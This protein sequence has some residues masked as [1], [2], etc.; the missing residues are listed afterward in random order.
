MNWPPDATCKRICAL[1]ALAYGS[2]NVGESTNALA[3]LKRL[4]AELG[5]SDVELA[6]IAEYTEKE[7]GARVD[8]GET[9][10]RPLNLLE[11]L[12][13]LLEASRIILPLAQAIT[14][15]L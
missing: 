10:E 14:A 13:L 12:L 8:L 5:L 6:F 9:S 3:A 1:S 4:Q 11:L 2:T 15:A 7:P